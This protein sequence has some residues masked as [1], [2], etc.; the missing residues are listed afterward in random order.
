MDTLV[1]LQSRV[2]TDFLL[3]GG[4][5]KDGLILPAPFQ[6]KNVV[7]A[8]IIA[9]LAAVASLLNVAASH[10]PA[11]ASVPT[12]SKE[13]KVT[14]EISRTKLTA[15]L[16]TNPCGHVSIVKRG[17]F[18]ENSATC[19]YSKHPCYAVESIS[20]R[21]ADLSIIFKPGVTTYCFDAKLHLLALSL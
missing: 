5:V 14:I 8:T 15:L 7:I 20:V 18:S 4:F 13:G 6:G 3:C 17:D 9:E 21:L 19:F 12:V 11:F 16:N 1:K 2:G 10:I